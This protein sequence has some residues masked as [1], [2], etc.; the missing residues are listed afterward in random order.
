LSPFIP[1][2]IRHIPAGNIRPFVLAFSGMLISIFLI[3]QCIFN[4]TEWITGWTK[5]GVDSIS[6]IQA[7]I[8]G[9]QR[10]MQATGDAFKKVYQFTFGWLK[11]DESKNLGIF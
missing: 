3:K 8:P 10:D 7:L 2:A 5:L 9:F 6:G 1:T 11:A 4:R